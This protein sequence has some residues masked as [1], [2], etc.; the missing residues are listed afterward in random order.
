M[1]T[2]TLDPILDRLAE[3]LSDSDDLESLVRPLL[4]LLE[5]VTGLESTYL[6]TI[7]TANNVQRILFA[8]NTREMTIPE[9]LAVP[10]GDTLCK[11]ALDE[12][13]AYTDDVDNCWGDSNAARELGIKTYLSEPVRVAAGE[14]YGTLCAASGSKV[15]VPPQ[16][17]RILVMFA[18]MIARQI[19][20]ERLLQNCRRRTGS[21]ASTR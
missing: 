1:T 3:A 15:E 9:G 18:R 19:E 21:S 6:T 12:G 4:E 14:L 16:K 17:R 5:A 8:R 11:R 2:A 20:R 7:D 13:R 10:W